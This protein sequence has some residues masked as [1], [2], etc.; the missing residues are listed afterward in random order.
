MLDDVHRFTPF[1]MFYALVMAAYFSENTR[2]LTSVLEIEFGPPH[3]GFGPV[4]SPQKARKFR[5]M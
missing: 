3:A 4:W 1:C 5:H 2:A